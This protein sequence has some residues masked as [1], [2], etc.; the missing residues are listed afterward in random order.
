MIEELFNKGVVV[1]IVTN[2]TLC[3]TSQLLSGLRNTKY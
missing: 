3:C 1:F 2:K